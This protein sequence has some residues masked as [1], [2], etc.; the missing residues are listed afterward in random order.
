MTKEA[1]PQNV[2]LYQKEANA[3]RLSSLPGKM[4]AVHFLDAPLNLLSMP[5]LIDRDQLLDC[6]TE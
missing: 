6:L 3:P 5:R 1:S 2:N 4:D